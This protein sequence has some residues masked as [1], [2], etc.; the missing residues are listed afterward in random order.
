M[1]LDKLTTNKKEKIMIQKA[2][3]VP[4][5]P[6]IIPEIGRG[7]EKTIQNT[8]DNYKKYAKEIVEL[9]PDTI[10]ITTPHSIMY[11]DYFHISPNE[12]AYGNFANFGVPQVNALVNYDTDLVNKISEI[13]FEENTPAGTLGERDPS[14]DHATLIP[15]YFI[16]EEDPDFLK[17]KKVIRIGLS[18]LPLSEH[19]KFGQEINEAIDDL[20]KK[21]VFIASGDLSHVLKEDGPYGFKKEGPIFDQMFQETVNSGN[22]SQFINYD[23]NLCSRASECGLRSF[24]ILAGA[25]DNYDYDTTLDSYEGPFGVGYGCAQVDIKGERNE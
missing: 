16:N 20:D 19:F 9:N 11:Q 24:A 14:L 25:L 5:P 18:G 22:L 17:N 15:L 3:I 2:F 12:K 21:V 1:D 10:V 4:H 8:I 23:E 7:E 6:L 13:A